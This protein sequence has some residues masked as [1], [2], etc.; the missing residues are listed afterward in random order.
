[1]RLPLAQIHAAAK[2]RPPGYYEAVTARGTIEGD[3]LEISSQALGELRA[4]Y[5]TPPNTQ[6]APAK[7]GLG[8]LV[9]MVATPIARAMH[10]TC[11]DPATR[12]LRPESKCAKRKAWLNGKTESRQP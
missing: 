9:A 7:R 4:I 1:M 10:L 5:R 8:D 12:D 2:D 11:I 6:P 3:Y